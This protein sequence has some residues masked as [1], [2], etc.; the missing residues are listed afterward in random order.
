[1]YFKGT[2]LDGQNFSNECGN[3]NIY[4]CILWVLFWMDRE[5]LAMNNGVF[6]ECEPG[7]TLERV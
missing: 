1:M 3:V 4:G 5:I 7:M 2:L 6:W